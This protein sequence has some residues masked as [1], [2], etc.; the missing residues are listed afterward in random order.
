MTDTSSF[1][2]VVNGTKYDIRASLNCRSSNVIYL[3]NCQRC[4]QTQYVGETGQAVHKRIYGHR[5]NISHFDPATY[6]HPLTLTQ[7]ATYRHEDTMVAK[8]FNEDGHSI[9]DMTVT[10]IEQVHS[11]D[12][13][14]RRRREKF[15]RHQLQ[16]NYPDG[17]NVFD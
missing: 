17:L 10:V 6:Q 8:H 7:D 4:A 1:H 2:S 3:I 5:H 15:W 13:A 11:L 14:L 9:D 16:T 12:T